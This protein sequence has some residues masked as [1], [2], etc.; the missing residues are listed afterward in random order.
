ML[1]VE[2]F[3]KLCAG[4]VEKGEP[5]L[6]YRH[7]NGF[8]LLRTGEVKY[9]TYRVVVEE[10]DHYGDYHVRVYCAGTPE[11]RDAIIRE[12]R[13]FSRPVL[14]VGTEEKTVNAKKGT[15]SKMRKVIQQ[16]R[17]DRRCQPLYVVEFDGAGLTTEGG[18]ELDALQSI[19]VPGSGDQVDA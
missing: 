3:V 19:P 16:L 10:R 5:F 12:A 7:P 9:E 17:K 18:P 2:Q 13:K 6:A 8:G 11:Q 4:H 1:S 14:K 15:V